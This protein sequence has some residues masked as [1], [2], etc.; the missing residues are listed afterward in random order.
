MEVLIQ[1]SGSILPRNTKISKV[2][3]VNLIK[4]RFWLGEIESIDSKMMNDSV[5]ISLNYFIQKMKLGGN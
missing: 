5:P 3:S 2:L 4:K 1:I